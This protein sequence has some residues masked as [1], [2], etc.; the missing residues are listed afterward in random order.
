MRIKNKKAELTSQQIITI[1][2]LIISF[3]VI[4]S[5]LIV[6][7]LKGNIDEETCRNS[8]ILR[9]SVPLAGTTDSIQLKCKTK[10]VCFYMDE[11]CRESSKET[12]NIKIE[13]KKQLL[14]ELGQ[15][16]YD[17]WWMMGAGEVTYEPKLK[18]SSPGM[19]VFCSICSNI[20]FDDE[21]KQEINEIKMEELYL[22]LASQKTADDR[23]YLQ[24][25]YKFDSM[26]AAYVEALKSGVDIYESKLDLT[27]PE[28]YALVTSI[29]RKGW[30]P[31]VGTGAGIGG[32]SGLVVVIG[33]AIAGGPVAWT[34]LSAVGVSAVGGVIGFA[35][36]GDEVDFA[37]PVFVP[38]TA[39]NIE[40][41]QCKDFSSMA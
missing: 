19:N 23:S 3:A 10:E 6:L 4:I 24:Y 32:V 5:F 36:S 12:E 13:D 17:C 41:M 22:N 8:V 35:V 25:L 29:M 26:E 14:D 34:A 37:S 40:K 7:N 30:I 20:Y 38:F 39:D 18:S 1:I 31:S 27:I 9:G 33:V 21:I 28:G 15:L 2:I 16:M 11:E